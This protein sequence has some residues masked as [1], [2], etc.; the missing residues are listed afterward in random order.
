MIYDKCQGG[1]RLEIKCK[2]CA[3]GSPSLPQSSASAAE[4]HEE[5]SS[6]FPPPTYEIREHTSK[7]P[8]GIAYLKEPLS[9]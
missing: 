3:G 2:R 8:L 9:M 5:M 1:D 4:S 7:R 6:L